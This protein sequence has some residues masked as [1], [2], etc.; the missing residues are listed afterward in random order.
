M[1][2]ISIRS[3]IIAPP[4]HV[5]VNWDLKQAESWVVAY[6]ANEPNMKRSL[7]ESDIHLDTAAIAF[8]PTWKTSREE[9]T[10]AQ[11]YT[12]KR[13]NHATSYRM[14]YRRATQVI[15]QDSDKPP[16]VVITFKESKELYDAWHSYYN[17][18]AWWADIENQLSRTRTLVTPYGRIRTFFAPWGEELYKEATAHVPQ[19]TVSDHFKGKIHPQLG[20]PGG[21]IEVH[22]QF[23]ISGAIKIIN[24]SHDSLIAEVHKSIYGEIHPQVT[25]LLRR[26]IVIRDEQ[27][28]IPVD[29][30][31][32][33]R[34]GELSPVE[35]VA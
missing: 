32:G 4:D 28:T 1:K 8:F 27:F 17:L 31:V 9:I 10:K 6:L 3:M 13:F 16:F 33:E 30:E 26:P 18:Q 20:I 14:G 24:E 34:W 7:A 25:A 19:S 12:A 22:K 35:A 29:C 2:K 5:L 11:R 23:V 15:N 21:L